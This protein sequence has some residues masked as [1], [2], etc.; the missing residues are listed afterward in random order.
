MVLL[1]L[2][3]RDVR[4]PAAESLAPLFEQVVLKNPADLQATMAP[5]SALTRSGRIDEGIDCLRRVIQNH[6]DR[7]EARDYLLTALDDSGRIDQMEE[8]LERL[9]AALA[10]SPRF[11]KHRARIAQGRLAGGRRSLPPGPNGR[12]PK[13][14]RRVPAQPGAA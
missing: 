13:P 6:P 7:I 2:A 11:L 14:Y 10:S 4:P 1:E 8:E 5:G 3:R 12:A 9:P